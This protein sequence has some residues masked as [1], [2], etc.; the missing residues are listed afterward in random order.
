MP[1]IRVEFKSA[2]GKPGG[3][4][5]VGEKSPTGGD[6]FAKRGEEKRVFL[7]PAYQEAALNKTTFDLRDKTVL[8]FDRNKVDGVELV[9]DGRTIQLAKDTNNW[10]IV[11]PGAAKA[12]YGTAEGLVTRLQTAQAKSFV[13]DAVAADLKKYGLDKPSV[14]AVV[15]AGSAR[16]TL[17]VGS[18]TADNTYY[19]KDASKNLVVTIDQ[20]LGDEL[21][22]GSDTYLLKDVFEMRGYNANKLDITRDS[23]VLVFDTT[24]PEAG[25]PGKWRRV[26]PNPADLEREKM[27]AFLSKLTGLRGI[28]YVDSTKNT[29]LDKPIL[30]VTGRYDQNKMEVVGFGKA[31]N[32]DIYAGRQGEDGAL[33]L[34]PKDFEEAT[35]ALDEIAK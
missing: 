10:K 25:K 14:T 12:D 11:K 22:R 9:A 19:A 23:Q 21:K 7:I 2:E 31:P 33:K 1:R 13:G 6:L 20:A 18:K 27:D 16:T 35:K 29:G 8:Q 5:L 4:L 3:T 28:G 26:S 34:D 30:A 15:N 17:L 32:G 24:T